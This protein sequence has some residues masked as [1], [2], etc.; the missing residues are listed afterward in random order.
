MHS[1]KRLKTRD[2]PATSVGIRPPRLQRF[3]KAI[4]ASKVWR[5]VKDGWMNRLVS[6]LMVDNK[7]GNVVIYTCLNTN[8][9][10]A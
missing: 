3:V 10:V 4:N 6:G 7:I 9:N 5:S 8:K 1:S 2:D